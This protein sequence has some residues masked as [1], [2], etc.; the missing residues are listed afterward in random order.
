MERLLWRHLKAK[1]FDG[2]K[3]RRQGPVGSY[4]ADFICFEKKLII[5][6]DG[7]QH[8]VHDEKDIERDAWF[9]RQGFT[10]LRFWNNDALSN[11]ELESHAIKDKLTLSGLIEK[12]LDDWMKTRDHSSADVQKKKE[13]QRKVVCF[14][15]RRIGRRGCECQ[16]R[17]F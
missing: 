5:E 2:H 16:M 17:L 14:S 15:C 7:G 8:A 6:V 9:E 10:V 3:F 12:V 4:I 1:R 13:G 11:K